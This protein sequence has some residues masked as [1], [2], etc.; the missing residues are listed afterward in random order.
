MKEM[1]EEC[2]KMHEGMHKDGGMMGMMG[3][4]NG[5]MSQEEHESHHQ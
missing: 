2:E 4:S 3:S 1:H 5:E